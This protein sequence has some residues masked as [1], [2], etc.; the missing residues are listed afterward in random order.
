MGDMA[1]YIN[2]DCYGAY[3]DDEVSPILNGSKKAR[4]RKAFLKRE[5][6]RVDER[7]RLLAISEAKTMEEMADAMG[8]PL[9]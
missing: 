6:K 1:D 4:R 2:Q 9:K 5:K 3:G 8:I 7:N